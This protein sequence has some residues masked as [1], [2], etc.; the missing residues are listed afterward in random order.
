MC[1]F[2]KATFTF[3]EKNVIIYSQLLCK[4]IEKVFYIT[5]TYYH[6]FVKG[7][8]ND[9]LVLFAKQKYKPIFKFDKK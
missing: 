7:N 8:G 2:C 9:K 3:G 5:I 4:I 6:Y 1:L